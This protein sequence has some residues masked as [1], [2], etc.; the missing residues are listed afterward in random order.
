M[1]GHVCPLFKEPIVPCHLTTVGAALA[2]VAFMVPL[3]GAGAVIPVS[4]GESVFESHS[5]ARLPQEP[6]LLLAGDWAGQAPDGSAVRVRLRVERG[7]IKGAADLGRALR[8]GDTSGSIVRP[9]MTSAGGVAF[10]LDDSSCD[11]ERAH[12]S[13]TLLSPSTAELIVSRAG[14][15]RVL[16]RLVRAP[17][18][19][20]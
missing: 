9:R 19:R 15:A 5:A 17:A 13:L 10:T 20:G 18:Q 1:N 8:G 14:G 2:L 12:G 4:E 3:A 11:S 7:V 16:I 6:P